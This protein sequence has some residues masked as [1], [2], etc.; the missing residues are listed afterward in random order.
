M[1]MTFESLLIVDSDFKVSFAE[2]FCFVR[3]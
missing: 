1:K 3:S 2:S